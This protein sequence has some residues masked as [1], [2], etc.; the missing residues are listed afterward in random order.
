MDLSMFMN[1]HGITLH[2]TQRIYSPVRPTIDTGKIRILKGFHNGE[3]LYSEPSVSVK[4]KRYSPTLIE[5][6]A[7]DEN[8]VVFPV[9]NKYVGATR[10]IPMDDIPTVVGRNMMYLRCPNFSIA[11]SLSLW[12]QSRRVVEEVQAA[13]EH[14]RSVTKLDSQFIGHIQVPEEILNP[15][16]VKKAVD[17]D[18]KIESNLREIN[19]LLLE[20]EDVGRGYE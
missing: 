20:L 17:I 19:Q 6:H 9:T 11:V 16:L 7:L 13:F 12:L 1:M 15:L 2:K 5:K 3:S 8:C 10:F 18:R 14:K 4:G